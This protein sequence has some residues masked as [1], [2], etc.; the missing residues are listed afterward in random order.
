MIMFGIYLIIARI[1][2]TFLCVYTLSKK[3]GHPHRDYCR[4]GGLLFY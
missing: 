1:I 3:R 4:L 2:I